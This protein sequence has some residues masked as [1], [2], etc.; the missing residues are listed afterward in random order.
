M[1]PTSTELDSPLPPLP[2]NV[3]LHGLIMLALVILVHLAQTVLG[4][5][6]P[7]SGSCGC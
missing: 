1:K 3:W 4:V 5:C 6:A 2:G 7:S